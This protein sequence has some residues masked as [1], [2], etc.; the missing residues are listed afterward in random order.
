MI[1]LTLPCFGIDFGPKR[2]C[3]SL[4]VDLEAVSVT[5]TT[6][7]VRGS[8]HLIGKAVKRLSHDRNAKI[9]AP[10]RTGLLPSAHHF[11]THAER[12]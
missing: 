2:E 6:I 5:S 10:A 8:L 3:L 4:A 9:D 12:R 1:L 7:T 11:P